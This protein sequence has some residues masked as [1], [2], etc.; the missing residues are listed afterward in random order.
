MVFNTTFNIYFG[1]IGGRNPEYPE[2]KRQP[3]ASLTNYHIMS[4]RVYIAMVI[5]TDCISSCKSNY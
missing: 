4:Y 5:D 1:F 3:A 2:K